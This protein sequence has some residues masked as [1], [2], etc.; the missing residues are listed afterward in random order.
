MSTTFNIFPK[1]PVIPTFRQVVDI[2]TARLQ[3]YLSS[4][5]IDSKY[6]IAVMLRSKEPDIEQPTNLD[7]PARWD[8]DLYAWFYVPS[9]PGGTD[10]YF[11]EVEEDDREYVMEDFHVAELPET[12]RALVLACLESDYYWNFRKSAT[13]PPIINVGY[14]LIAASVAELTDGFIYSGDGGWDVERFPATAEEFYQWYFRPE[15]AI[16]PEKKQ[17]AERCLKAIGGKIPAQETQLT[18]MIR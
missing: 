17:W 12:R 7:S 16:H 10:A 8:D 2:A 4:Y 14:G 6:N 3:Q 18:K 15:Q 5:G 13:Q 11:W 9:V 1:L